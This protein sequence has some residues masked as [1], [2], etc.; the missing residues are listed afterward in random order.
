MTQPHSHQIAAVAYERVESRKYDHQDQQKCYGALVHKLPAMI[1]QNGL[2][3][4]TG[5][6][7]AKGKEEHRAV[8]EDLRNIFNQTG[9]RYEDDQ[10]FHQAIIQADLQKTMM[11]TRHALEVAGWMRRYVQGI[12]KINSTGDSDKQNESET[13]KEADL[14]EASQS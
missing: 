7:L 13:A 9:H 5:F 6:L 10:A 8:L 11:I 12:L 4:A 3:H 14:Q 1:L 2:A